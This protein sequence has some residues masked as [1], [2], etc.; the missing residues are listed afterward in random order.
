MD[1]VTDEGI[2]LFAGRN[3]VPKRSYR[4]AYSSS[5][6]DQAIDRFR[7]AWFTEVPRAGLAYGTSL[8]LD[9]HTVPANRVEEPLEKH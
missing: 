2:A 6:D 3:V 8:D 5:I 1:L 4:A 9:L 7:A